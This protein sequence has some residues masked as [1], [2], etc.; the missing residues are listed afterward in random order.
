MLN[1]IPEIRIG[2]IQE[3]VVCLGFDGCDIQN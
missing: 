2:I 1:G 3:L